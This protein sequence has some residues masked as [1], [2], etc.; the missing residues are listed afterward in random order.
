MNESRQFR[1]NI[2]S[3]FETTVDMLN[4]RNMSPEVPKSSWRRK[5]AYTYFDDFLDLRLPTFKTFHD[6][7]LTGG[8]CP[9][10]FIDGSFGSW[11]ANTN[12]YVNDTALRDRVCNKMLNR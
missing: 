10:S 2:D 6:I 1:N 3:P 11:N 7:V 5:S 4:P 8:R 12:A 9:W